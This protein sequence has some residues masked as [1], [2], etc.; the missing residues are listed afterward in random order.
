M[1]QVSSFLEV[2]HTE[3]VPVTSLGAPEILIESIDLIYV[4]KP[5]GILVHDGEDSLE[6]RV[7]G[8]L[9]PSL[10]PSLSFTPGPLHRLDRN[11][12][13]VV[14]FSKTLRGARLFSE[15]MRAGLLSKVYI[16][17]L[18]GELYEREM[19]TDFLQRDE[20]LRKTFVSGASNIS[21]KDA[22][23]S[24]F[25]IATRD[26]KTLAALRLDTGRTHQIRAQAASRAHPLM[27][28]VKYGALQ[29][30][31]PYYLHAWFLETLSDPL[32]GL[33]SLVIAPL[34]DYFR[35]ILGKLFSLEEKGVYS[36]LKQCFL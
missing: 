36:Q 9:A 6:A 10:L 2:T 21:N 8:Y 14:T 17:I 26:G 24:V 1:I 28:D 31:L 12:S 29:A 4:N 23:T 7:R 18:M 30:A 5:L 35:S 20:G 27:G 34:P 15:A 33:A 22:L 13:G 25:P 16:A 11:S 32:P 3:Q 19:W